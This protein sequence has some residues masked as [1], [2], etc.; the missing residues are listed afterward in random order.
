MELALWNLRGTVLSGKWGRRGHCPGWIL[1]Q[2]QLFSTCLVGTQPRVA[3]VT[4]CGGSSRQVYIKR[5]MVAG[6]HRHG[7]EVHPR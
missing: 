6:T 1:L 5:P 2:K 7:K 4:I 3:S